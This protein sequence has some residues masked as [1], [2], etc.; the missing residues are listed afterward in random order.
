MKKY[1]MGFHTQTQTEQ[2]T[3]SA[4]AAQEQAAA[5]RK[6]VVQVYFAHRG[7]SW[8]YYNDSFD[9]KVG[10]LV[11]VDGKLEGYQGRV[12]EVS[13]T[14]KIK[15]S[16]YKRVIAVADTSVT[17]DLY[18]TPSHML[19]FDAQQLPYNKVRNWFL[20]PLKAEDEFVSGDEDGE[21]IPLDDL[22][23]L[24]ISTYTAERGRDYYAQGRVAYLC[25]DGTHGRAIVDGSEK[26]EVEFDYT[27]GCVSRLTCA[28][29]CSDVCEHEFAVLLQ[30][31]EILEL[32]EK[33]YGA[34]YE[35]YFAALSK[36]AFLA[37]VFGGIQAGKLSLG[38]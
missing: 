12:V 29:Y 1:Q 17:G 2:A 25:L 36:S 21:A 15:L 18:F 14:F 38:E 20:A 30:L 8:P 13:Y 24:K 37:K 3:Q 10:D 11:Y 19:C 4:Q 7:T 16:D 22:S 33:Q 35:G 31:K 26:Y 34:Q 23:K 32:L 28:C 27:D 9:L 6:S 5:P